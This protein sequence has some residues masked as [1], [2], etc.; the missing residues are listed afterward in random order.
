MKENRCIKCGAVIPEGRQ[1]CP[2]CENIYERLTERLDI[3]T[4]KIAYTGDIYIC[5]DGSEIDDEQITID[6]GE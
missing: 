4:N 1:V 6:L 5:T 3:E 2:N